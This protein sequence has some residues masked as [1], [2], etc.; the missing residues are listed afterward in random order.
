[1]KIQKKIGYLNQLAHNG[2][3]GVL[4]DDANKKFCNMSI[5][6]CQQKCLTTN[7]NQCLLPYQHHEIPVT[8]NTCAAKLI[9]DDFVSCPTQRGRY[10]TEGVKT[11]LSGTCQMDSCN[12][13]DTCFTNSSAAE[14]Q[15]ISTNSSY[16]FDS[17]YVYATDANCSFKYSSESNYYR[18]TFYKLDIHCEDAVQLSNTS[19]GFSYNLCSKTSEPDYSGFQICLPTSNVEILFET[20]NTNA[21][22]SQRAGFMAAFEQI[23]QTEC[24]ITDQDTACYGSEGR[25][26][27]SQETLRSKFYPLPYPANSSC[28]WKIETPGDNLAVNISVIHLDLGVNHE[29]FSV[30]D[31]INVSDASA[32]SLVYHPGPQQTSYDWFLSVPGAA[33]VHFES[34]Y[35]FNWHQNFQLEVSF[36]EFADQLDLYVE[37]GLCVSRETPDVCQIPFMFEGREYNVCEYFETS[38][39]K[40]S[41]ISYTGKKVVCEETLVACG[42]QFP[43]FTGYEVDYTDI[44][45]TMKQL[46]LSWTVANKF[47]DFFQIYVNG[48]LYQDS[49]RETIISEVI[50]AN[51][52]DIRLEL[53]VFGYIE[54][55]K[56]LHITLYPQSSIQASSYDGFSTLLLEWPEGIYGNLELL[57]NDASIPSFETFAQSVGITA[58]LDFISIQQS[59]E[60]T[61][62]DISPGVTYRFSFT[63][64][65]AEEIL[66]TIPPNSLQ[67]FQ[68]EQLESSKSYIVSGTLTKD[69]IC[70]KI[71]FTIATEASTTDSSVR[72]RRQ[73]EENIV[74]CSF[75]NGCIDSNGYFNADI[76]S[77][78][79]QPDTCYVMTIVSSTSDMESDPSEPI[80]ICTPAENNDTNGTDIVPPQRELLVCNLGCDNSLLH[81]CVIYFLMVQPG[82]K[83]D[84]KKF[85][86]CFAHLV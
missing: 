11:V 67:A 82:K 24:A 48:A 86:H 47:W 38:D 7:G 28:L 41:C 36:V 76:T 33:N 39:E 69:T 70:M 6:A 1:M 79:P 10:E 25:L 83:N 61:I 27:T 37:A 78:L 77:A 35:L 43:N 40:P 57:L 65:Q 66:F 85:D 26:V 31:S 84:Q 44:D 58:P 80:T 21:E 60:Y 15:L 19:G 14:G 49:V 75:E 63:G 4:S 45:D 32:R 34:G 12:V 30:I 16:I 81:L 3:S 29:Q 62:S 42:R 17:K 68:I 54:V 9:S 8:I 52:T 55:P 74:V 51:E 71:V 22:S 18:F 13:L 23:S 59:T 56:S 72:K 46:T 20:G 73:T 5:E 2:V 50:Q 64:N 53:I